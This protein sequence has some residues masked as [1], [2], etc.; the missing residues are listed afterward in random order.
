M[1][2]QISVFYENLCNMLIHDVCEYECVHVHI[3]WQTRLKKNY[4]HMAH[5][6]F[7]NHISSANS[8]LQLIYV[9]RL[10]LNLII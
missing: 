2:I 1:E 4:S 10:Y 9:L 6:I 3:K 8:L 5:A 7:I